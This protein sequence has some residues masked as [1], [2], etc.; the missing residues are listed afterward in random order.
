MVTNYYQKF[1]YSI[2]WASYEQLGYQ[3]ILLAHQTAL[4]YVMGIAAYGLVGTAFASIYLLSNFLNLGLDATFS[5]FLN[6]ALTG[7]RS[8]KKIVIFPLIVQLFIFFILIFLS[9]AL[10]WQ[11]WVPLT[12]GAGIILVVAGGMTESYKRTL[13]ILVQNSFYIKEAAFIAVADIILYVAIIWT[14]YWYWG[15]LTIHN[16]VMPLIG[17][18]L[19]SILLLWYLVYKIYNELP[20]EMAFQFSPNLG[21]RILKTRF[22]G[23]AQRINSQF[24]SSNLLI[25]LSALFF[26]AVQTGILTLISSYTYFINS[27]IKKTCEISSSALFSQSTI[28]SRE[29][30]QSLFNKVTGSTYYMLSLLGLIL[31]MLYPSALRIFT[32]ANYDLLP[33]VLFMLFQFSENFLIMYEKFFI[34]EEKAATLF[35]INAVTLPFYLGTLYGYQ[36]LPSHLGLVFIIG[37]RLATL[38]FF[39]LFSLY[40]W[41]IKPAIPNPRHVVYAATASASFAYFL[42]F[43]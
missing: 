40:W 2:R 18:S 10:V 31:V 30:K 24:F 3:A 13:R 1:L 32:K 26:G 19:L 36:S 14:E 22:L 17:T 42:S 16:L 37:I 43:I 6:L 21:K 8:F 4:S 12:G 34:A 38:A 35:M 39:I 29:E 41:G 28:L 25:P 5:P 27:L 7:K 9:S 23:L 11:G 15:S 33:I 20:T